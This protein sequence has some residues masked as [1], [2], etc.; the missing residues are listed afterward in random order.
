MIV[1][2]FDN[3]AVEIFFDNVRTR[4]FVCRLGTWC[5]LLW[6]NGHYV[7]L[8]PVRHLN[9]FLSRRFLRLADVAHCVTPL[10]DNA[11]G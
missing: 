4:R 10:F 9:G 3:E 6:L 8:V 5:V 11:P 2:P 7:T 1:K